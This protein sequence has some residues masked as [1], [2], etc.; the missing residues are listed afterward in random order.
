MSLQKSTAAVAA[1]LLVVLGSAA[2]VA[3]N[4]GSPSVA[5][6]D[7]AKQLQD[8]RTATFTRTASREGHPAVTIKETFVGP[9]AIRMESSSGMIMVADQEKEKMLTLVPA[10]KVAFMFDLQDAPDRD[11]GKNWLQDVR[12]QIRDA[13]QA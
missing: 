12:Q 13:D 9:S 6:A 7:V 1:C 4:F 2:F 10:Q 3:F 11:H 8:I 5:L